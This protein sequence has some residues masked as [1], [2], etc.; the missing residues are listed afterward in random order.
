MKF[1]FKGLFSK[2]KSSKGPPP[3]YLNPHTT[4]GELDIHLISEGR[5]EKLW[6]ALGANVIRDNSGKLLGTSFAVWA[7]NATAVSLICD[8]NNWDRICNPMI[9]LGSNGL[10]ELFL[11]D[12]EPGTKYKYSVLN[13]R[14]NWV[15]HAD[16]M[17]RETEIPPATASIVNENKFKWSDTEW[18]SKR[19]TFQPWQSPISIYEV[20][21]GSWKPGLSYLQLASE[22]TNY[23]KSQGFTHVEFL[24]VCEHPYSP[25]WGYQVTSYFAPTARFGSPDEFRYL[26]NQLH[27]AGIGVILDWVP[28]HFPKDEWALARFDGTALYEHEDPRLGEHP[29]WGTYIFNYGRNEVR[30]FLV[31]SALYWIEEFHIDGLR[32]DAVAS[33]L[34]LDY[35]R[36]EGEWIPN[37]DGGRE[38]LEAVRFLQEATATAYKKFPGI[39]MI[40]E[41][42]TAWDGV[43]RATTDNGLGFGFKWNMGWMHDTLQYL[44][45]E[46]IHRAYHHNEITFSILYAWSE[47][48]LLPLSH[49]EVV[50][51]KR[52]LVNKFPGD[53]W[54]K[55][56]T[57]RALYGYMWSHPGK[58]LLFMGG[59]FAQ[60]EEWREGASLDWH[61]TQ[62]D[63]HLGIQELIKKLN[64]IYVEHKELWELDTKN[65]GFQWLSN[66]DSSGNILAYSRIDASGHALISITN[67][68][69]VPQ[70]E[71]RLPLGSISDNQW[72]EILNTDS[73]EFGG[74]GV[75]N[76]EPITAVGND[77][78]KEIT[79]RVPPLG[80][81]WLAS[82]SNKEGN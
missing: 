70:L 77:G 79:L 66:N 14:G 34:Y 1:S 27:Q 39:M 24:P 73:S 35:S 5:H 63:E 47:N 17:A 16:P 13:Q 52:S 11:A 51:G 7:P 38:N 67:F 71:Y 58:K 40:A 74:S 50:H 9:P 60:N 32:V 19:E 69:P 75:I 49:D 22:L 33:M 28:A 59:E 65:S 20:H 43:T 8:K 53:R 62:Y 54:Q 29:D 21:L 57:L 80:T 81:L 68:S 10:W 56:A 15:E 3:G 72:V 4:I 82:C 48:F 55:L 76:T 46:P 6:R 18:I 44:Q 12:I 26:I 78:E 30:N 23:V 41:E 36:K 37:K 64:S 2:R 45:R 61:L 25:S 42:S 31:A